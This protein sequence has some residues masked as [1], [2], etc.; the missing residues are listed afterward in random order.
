MLWVR[1]QEIRA[2]TLKSEASSYAQLGQIQVP[3][4]AERIGDT[5][6]H[7]APEDAPIGRNPLG[8]IRISPIPAQ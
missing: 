2:T 1:H 5:V 3:L 8:P 6:K 4:C 7:K